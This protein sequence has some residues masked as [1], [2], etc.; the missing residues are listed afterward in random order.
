MQLVRSV[1]V[2]CLT[3]ALNFAKATVTNVVEDTVMS[4]R[5]YTST[6]RAM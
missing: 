3:F 2:I 4:S 1:L 6:T 5:C